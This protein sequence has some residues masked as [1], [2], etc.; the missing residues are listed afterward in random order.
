MAGVAAIGTSAL[1]VAGELVTV[2]AASAALP[3]AAF[4]DLGTAATYDCWVAPAS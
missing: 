3:P 1:L 4:V 2:S